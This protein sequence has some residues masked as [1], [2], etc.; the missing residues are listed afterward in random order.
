MKIRFRVSMIAAILMIVTTLTATSLSSVYMASARAARSTAE[1][2]FGGVVQGTRERIEHVI[3]Q[4]LY[5]AEL[6][7]AQ[8]SAGEA[9]RAGLSAPVLPFLFTALTQN[10]TLYSLYYGYADGDFLQLIPVRGDPRILKAHDAP[11]G[12]A[13]VVRSIVGE[14]RE[15]AG[16]PVEAGE[17]APGRRV[18]TWTFL[19]DDHAV[20][21]QAHDENPAYDPRQ[22]PW[23]MAAWDSPQPRL[24]DAYVFNSL[25]QPGITSSRRL[26]GAEGV[27]GADITLDGLESF[28]S[29]QS[30][31]DN[32]SLV[33]FDHAGRT[34][35]ASPGLGHD[36]PLT[37][38]ARLTLPVALETV[39]VDG[40]VRLM[41]SDT[42]VQVTRWD[43]GGGTIDIAVLAPVADF[44]GNIRTM[45]REIV[46]LAV[47]G[48][49]ILLP[50][51]LMFSSRMARAVHA[52]ANDAERV[53]AM[54]FSGG[55]APRSRIT[56][57]DDLGQ[58]FDLMKQA[59]GSKTQALS[60]AQ[61]KL[62]RV[63]DLG[64]AMAAERDAA[65]LMEMILLG[66]KELTNADGGTLYTV[67][68]EGLA[69]Q[70]LRN[71]TLGVVLGGSSGTA[72]TLPPVPLFEPG[73]AL[74][75]A[76][77]VSHAV[78]ENQTVIIDDAYDSTGFDFSGTKVFDARTGYR[79]TSFMTVPLK[80]RGGDVIGALQLINAR[81]AQGKTIPFPP[82]IQR[83]VEA[84]AAQAATILYNLQLLDEQERLMDSMI[85]LIAGAIDSKSPYTGGHCERVPELATML[86]EA[87][88]AQTDGPLADFAF[89]TEAEWREFRIG[90]WLHDCGKVVTPEYVVDKATKLETIFNRINEVRTRF[91][92]LWRDAEI[93]RLEAVAA[94][95]D[96]EDA[97]RLRDARQ[98]R[99][100]DDFAFIAE[101]NIGGE[102]M[103][104]DKVDRLKAIAATPWVRHF[105]DRLGLGHEE[106]KRFTGEPAVLPAA[107]TL[108]S[109]KEHHVIPREKGLHKLY[110]G[111]GFKNQVPENL[112]NMGE[113]YNLSVGR[114]TLTEE[115]RFK[116]NEHIMQT[117]AMLENLPFPKHL[118][119]VPEYAGTHH[120]T[121]TGTGYP[122]KL[123]AAD[124]SVPARIMAVADIF[125]ALTA[126]DRPYKKAKTLSESVKILSFFKKDGH[127]DGD[128]FDLFLTSGVYRRYAARFLLPEQLDE[129]NISAYV[130]RPADE[131][132]PALT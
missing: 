128:I 46:L 97:S 88:S 52:L 108:L 123:S 16:V 103:A 2:V 9:A 132:E 90:A 126:S 83:F 48:L 3:T 49:V 113:V 47:L 107:E 67:T 131:T 19:D 53:R 6:G 14:E 21:G 72:V 129:V 44:T 124:L 24:S 32:G 75:H 69:F 15:E 94:G 51:A 1:A 130:T 82:A 125:E 22:R 34:L 25:Q 77:V 92:V 120:E 98:Q 31:S 112:Y 104:P 12:T 17:P 28:V 122:R 56:E 42:L 65:R 110:A 111:L 66:A 41:D 80:P 26:A 50:A 73:G 55:P 99:L 105:D 89:T 81:D 101:C 36:Q 109:D 45:Q 18:Q 35:A 27:F 85:Q 96:P 115:E 23:Y 54:D 87:A 102:F 62:T 40:T 127:I 29:G 78:H 74:N 64:I 58:S 20:I 11:P 59:L 37:P 38:L 33:L 100:K 95:I 86:A 116:I 5:L 114:G 93:E 61:A 68:P 84:L 4:T 91:E 8:A 79:S 117:I 119:R 39:A 57:F 60:E 13:W 76:N 63:V 71:D 118:S 30:I 106:L 7:A 43:G 10:R 121:L 70:I